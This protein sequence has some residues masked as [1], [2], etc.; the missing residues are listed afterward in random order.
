MQQ[1]EI[2]SEIQELNAYEEQHKAQLK[3]K[4]ENIRSYVNKVENDFADM[5][6]Q[7]KIRLDRVMQQRLAS[8]QSKAHEQLE[9]QKKLFERHKQNLKAIYQKKAESAIKKIADELMNAN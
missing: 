2:N 4:E 3:Q 7:E 9:N 1:E 6:S 8:A 5:L